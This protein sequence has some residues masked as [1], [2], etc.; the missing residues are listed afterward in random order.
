MK[1]VLITGGTGTVGSAFIKK[2]Y[3]DYQFYSIS[4]GEEKIAELNSKFPKVKTFIRNINDL[5]SLINTFESIKPDIEIHAAALKHVNLAELNPSKSIEINLNGS[6]NV[7][8]ASIRAKVP[9]TVGISTDKACSPENV[10]GYTK[11][12]MEQVFMEHHNSETKF[13]CTRFANVAN[14]RGSVIPFFKDLLKK[15]QPLKLTSADMNRLMFS[16]KD[17]STLIH[18]AIDYSYKIEDSFILSKKMKS[19]NMLKLAQTMSNNI[20]IVGLRPGEKLNENL[21][22]NKELPYTKLVDDYIFLYSDKQPKENNLIESF[23]SLNSI[24]MS[25]EEIK[26]LLNEK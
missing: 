2:Y 8:K 14:S 7:V 24:F 26:I 3:N 9:L 11:K 20:D 22:S 12:M 4:R 6:L 16:S 5:D 13:V 19:V 10:Y 23:S 21:I 18:D 15:N 1:K 17:A 25:N